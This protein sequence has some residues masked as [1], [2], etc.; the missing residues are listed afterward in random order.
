ML[1]ALPAAPGVSAQQTA[2]ESAAVQ[3]AGPIVHSKQ[4]ALAIFDF[5]GPGK[6]VTVLGEKLADD[7]SAA[8]TKSAGELQVVDRSRVEAKRKENHYAPEIVLD[9]LSAQL[10]AQE[11]G[12]KAIIIGELSLGQ[13]N[14]LTVDLKAYRVDNGKGIQGLRISF[15][16]SEDMAG[17]MAKNVS[18]YDLP[19]NLFPKYPKSN[20][21]GYSM[22]SC[23]DCP[24]ADYTSQAMER[25]LEGVV[26]LVAI[27]EADGR[28]TNIAVVKGL[29]GGLTLQAIEAIKKWRL[30]PATGPD[31]KPVAVRQIIEVVFRVFN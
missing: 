21:P 17:L 4:H 9:P 1:L 20:A 16:L 8:I 15:P 22:P 12:A 7:F 31:G 14:A 26:E 3:L 25:R 2:M 23:I 6:K 30:K 24:R 13:K 11:L 18:S 19:D 10:F 28:V 29:P 5:S 27:V